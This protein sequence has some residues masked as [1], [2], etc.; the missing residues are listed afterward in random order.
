MPLSQPCPDANITVNG[1]AAEVAGL[2]ASYRNSSLDV[3]FNINPTDAQAPSSSTFYVTGG[4][5]T[6]P[7]LLSGFRRTARRR[8]VSVY[9]PRVIWA[10][11]SMDISVHWGSGGTNDLSHPTT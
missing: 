8:S 11:H 1:A 3:S 2:S 5:A 9:S 7:T 10:I 4:G 6:V